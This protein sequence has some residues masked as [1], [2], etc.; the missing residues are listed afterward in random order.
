[1]TSSSH[2]LPGPE[3]RVADVDVPLCGDRISWQPPAALASCEPHAAVRVGGCDGVRASYQEARGWRATRHEGRKTSHDEVDV[4]R[5][6]P[7]RLLSTTIPDDRTKIHV[8]RGYH[9]EQRRYVRPKIVGL[10]I[11][12]ALREVH[13]G[14]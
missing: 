6:S 14:R 3:R 4:E 12:S 1:M 10:T 8:A 2:P 7:R 9:Y 5:R 11:Y 13:C